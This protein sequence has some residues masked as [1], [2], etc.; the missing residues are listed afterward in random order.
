VNLDGRTIA[1]DL[2]VGHPDYAPFRDSSFAI[3]TGENRVTL[4]RGSTVAVSGRISTLGV[5]VNDV[6]VSVDC[7]VRLP[8]DAWRRQSDGRLGA[9]CA[10]LPWGI[11]RHAT[12]VSGRARF[13]NVPKD[14]SVFVGADHGSYRMR[15]VDRRHPVRVAVRAGE[16]TAVTI[17]LEPKDS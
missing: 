7:D 12:D 9:G 1:V 10:I 15:V 5:V 2:T 13:E 17:V 16:T 6:R 11:W 3:R 14:E 8:D 4:R